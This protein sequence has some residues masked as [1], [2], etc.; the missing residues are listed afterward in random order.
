MI[1]SSLKNWHYSAV[2]LVIYIGI[3]HIWVAITARHDA[4][5]IATEVP[6]CGVIVSGLSACTLLGVYMLLAPGYFTDTIDRSA[7]GMVILDIGLEAVFPIIHNN[8]NFYLCTLAFVVVVGGNH[9]RQLR[10]RAQE[11][12]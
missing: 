5:T 4:L 2:M 8:Y 7:H 11:P 1:R 6:L 3:F 10:K 9:F 12:A